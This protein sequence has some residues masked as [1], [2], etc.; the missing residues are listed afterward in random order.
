MAKKLLQG[1]YPD[2]LAIERTVAFLNDGEFGV[3]QLEDSDREELRR[4][5][6]KWL[7]SEANWTRFRSRMLRLE[8]EKRKKGRR[9]KCKLFPYAGTFYVAAGETGDP[10]LILSPAKGTSHAQEVFLQFFLHPDHL[11]LSGPCKRVE[12]GRYFLR[13]TSHPKFYC[14]QR[15]A[16]LTTAPA[17]MKR[18][19]DAQHKQQVEDA[20]RAISK[21]ERRRRND[22]WK[23]WVAS[24]TEI[25]AR[26]LSGWVKNGELREPAIRRKANAKD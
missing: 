9:Y 5:T 22:D 2:P 18:K 6:E 7:A 24:E 15:C 26:T 13:R 3:E 8:A 20:Q 17:A 25:T 1:Y 12:C 4:L 16:S 11:Q 14:T 21:W 23:L 19:R 10:I